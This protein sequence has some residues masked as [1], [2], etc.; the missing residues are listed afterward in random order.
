[1]LKSNLRKIYREKRS[2]LTV[3]ERNKLDD[4][5]LIQFQKLSLDDV[6]VLLTYSPSE[7]MAEPNTF[8]FSN[9]L[10]H[11]IPGLEIC[12]PVTDFD[13]LE[14]QARQVNDHTAFHLT[15]F[16]IE[17]PSDGAEIDPQQIDLVFVPML[18][19]DSKGYRVGFGKGFY[20]RFLPKCRPGVL[21]LGF[22]YFEPVDSIDDTHQFD[23][24]LD[25]CI[26][27]ERVIEFN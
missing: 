13:T 6:Q 18:I 1:M 14:M 5:L 22:S 15:E 20:D 3:K 16:G 9:Y 4:L 2:L 8:L 23:I 25:F 10:S 27:P 21:K 19:C 17:E 12:Y 7:Q 11:M 26:T 24:P